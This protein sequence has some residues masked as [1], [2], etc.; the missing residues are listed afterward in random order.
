MEL[1][2]IEMI[3][4]TCIQER[5]GGIRLKYLWDLRCDTPPLTSRIIRRFDLWKRG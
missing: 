3:P 2:F 5:N 1:E 4:G